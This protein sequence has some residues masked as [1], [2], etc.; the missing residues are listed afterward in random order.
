MFN[1]VLPVHYAK[2]GIPFEIPL[3]SNPSTGYSWTIT[4]MPH[5]LRVINEKFVPDPH[6]PGLVGVGGTQVFTF[7]AGY[8]GDD[9]LSFVYA[10]PWGETG[11]YYTVRV[12]A[13]Y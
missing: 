1:R 9:V 10:T 8:A 3:R 2:V 6:P 7:V 11:N 5:Y 4:Y 13:Y 12:I